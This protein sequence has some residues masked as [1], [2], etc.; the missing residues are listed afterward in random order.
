MNQLDAEP[1]RATN[2]DPM[3]PL[4]SPDGAWLAYFARGGNTLQKI[5]SSGGAPVTLAELP[6][7]PQG[8]AWQGATIVFAM[9]SATASGI[10]TV[11][12]GGGQPQPLLTVD[13]VV[14]RVSQPRLL[15]DRRHVLFTVTPPKVVPGEGTIMSSSPWTRVSARFS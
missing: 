9:N 10:F 8:A 3:E 15:D 6:A 13:P 7:P 2:E 4:F 1:M 14:E 11:S 5:A 12:E